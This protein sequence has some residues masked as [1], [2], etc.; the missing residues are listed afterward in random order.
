VVRP[1]GGG[2]RLLGEEL[3]AAAGSSTAMPLGSDYSLMQLQVTT[4]TD[5]E[6]V[7]DCEQKKVTVLVIMK[8]EAL[9]A[10]PAPEQT[11]EIGDLLVVMGQAEQVNDFAALL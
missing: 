10:A 4:Q 2:G 6:T 11:I 3:V 5:F 7:A 1:V 8:G 9:I